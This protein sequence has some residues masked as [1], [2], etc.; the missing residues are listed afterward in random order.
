MTSKLLPQPPAHGPPGWT[1][2]RSSVRVTVTALLCRPR[3][4]PHLAR[5]GGCVPGPLRLLETLPRV[6]VGSVCSVQACAAGPHPV[7]PPSPG[8]DTI[9]PGWKDGARSGGP[10]PSKVTSKSRQP[11]PSFHVGHFLLPS[12][13]HPSSHGESCVPMNPTSHPVPAENM[14]PTLGT[15]K[16]IRGTE[17]REQN[18]S[19]PL[20]VTAF[21]P[22]PPPRRHP[23]PGASHPPLKPAH[24]C[25]QGLWAARACPPNAPCPPPFHPALVSRQLHTCESCTYY[26][27]G[28]V[29]SVFFLIK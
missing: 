19:A 16:G 17:S 25:A 5:P 11:C 24:P 27:F 3:G 20:V 8:P 9:S 29:S 1:R 10:S 28:V 2:P 14:G 23:C 22:L 7:P 15:R 18:T 13:E 4:C 26:W 6:K 12:W 21:L